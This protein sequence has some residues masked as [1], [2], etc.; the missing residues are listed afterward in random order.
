MLE[1]GQIRDLVF[2]VLNVNALCG[3]LDSNGRW[4]L[5]LEFIFC[6]PPKQ[7]GFADAW[8]ANQYNFEHEVLL[9]RRRDQH[10]V[11]DSRLRLSVISE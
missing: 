5:H 7:V 1:A 10:L 2:T 11:L 8:V 6:V 3:E 9:V 4:R